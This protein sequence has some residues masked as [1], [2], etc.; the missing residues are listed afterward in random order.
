[1]K[2]QLNNSS[3]QSAIQTP[4]CVSVGMWHPLTVHKPICRRSQCKHK[5]EVLITTISMWRGSVTMHFCMP[6]SENG[7][8]VLIS[9]DLHVESGHVLRSHREV[10]LSCKNRQGWVAELCSWAKL[11]TA[12]SCWQKC[13][14]SYVIS[15]CF[16]LLSCQIRTELSDPCWSSKCNESCQPR[17][18]SPFMD[19]RGEERRGK[20]VGIN[21]EVISL[22]TV[23]CC[24]VAESSIF[25]GS[26]DSVEGNLL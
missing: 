6:S 22:T 18:R 7:L 11:K 8:T 3:W 5:W 19:S 1:M 4:T 14:N 21:T 13:S 9:L 15:V 23:C 17:E 26:G 2:S 10:S 25:A 24:V 20:I 12:K 16:S